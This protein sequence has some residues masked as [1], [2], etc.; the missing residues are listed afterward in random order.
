MGKISIDKSS[1]YPAYTDNYIS[2][3]EEELNGLDQNKASDI[4]KY[5][6]VK[7]QKDVADLA[8][9]YTQNSWQAEV[10][11][12][13]MAP[14]MGEINNYKYVDKNESKLAES[15][16][17]Y[18]E[19]SKALKEN[20]WKYFANKE[21]EN[22]NLQLEQLNLL[23]EQDKENTDLQLQLKSL[24]LQKE[25]VTLRL[26]KDIKY[27]SEDYK[28]LAIQRYRMYMEN[29]SQYALSLIHI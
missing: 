20:N 8:K 18:D 10:I 4:N 7:S 28:S 19:M 24:E 6:E 13:V 11:E 29:Y 3:L 21:L 2:Y 27:G 12:N 22:V 26:E 15:N 16:A 1:S 25:V 17:K 23:M 14:I 9:N 5:A